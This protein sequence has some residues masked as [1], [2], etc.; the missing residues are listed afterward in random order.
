MVEEAERFAAE[1]AEYQKQQDLKSELQNL[2]YDLQERAESTGTVSKDMEEKVQQCLAWLD[3]LG[4]VGSP[5]VGR[6]LE[7]WLRDLRKY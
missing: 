3:G 5:G 2:A 4:A 1:D 7:H 6:S